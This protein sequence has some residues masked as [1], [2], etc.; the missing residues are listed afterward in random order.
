MLL[1]IAPLACATAPTA[2]APVVD[3]P[4]PPAP[5]EPEP[6]TGCPATVADLP[7]SDLFKRDDARLSGEALIVVLKEARRLVV[8]S[9]GQQAKTADG[10]AACWSVA[11]AGSYVDGHKQK[12]GDMRTPEG[13]QRTSDRPWSQ[14]Y[15][16]LTV[17]YPAAHDAERGLRDGLITQEQHDAIVAAD[18]NGTLPPMNTAL[19]GLIV[20]HGGGGQSDWTLGCVALDN[21]DIDAM[22]TLLPS[23]MRTDLLVLP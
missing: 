21:D 10:D 18:R 17:H 1:F 8:F 15:S 19:G 11:L 4:V 9:D 23:N 20:I 12:R 22:R 3:D 14:F 6:G 16:A 5:V 7:D 2:P 13:W